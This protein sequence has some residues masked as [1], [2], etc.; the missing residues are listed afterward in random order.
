MCAPLWTATTVGPNYTAPAIA[1]GVVYLGT[2][3]TRS[4]AGVLDAFD[5]HGSTGCSGS[6]KVCT[7]L[8]RASFPDIVETPAVAAGYVYAVSSAGTLSAFD[9][10]GV[11]GCGGVPRTCSPRW[12]AQTEFGADAPIVA[13]GVVY[14][15]DSLA[16][17]AYD[18]VGTLG[19]SGS[20]KRCAPIWSSP[21]IS[22][23][24]VFDPAVVDGRLF[25]STATATFR[26][27]TLPAG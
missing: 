24:G 13:N 23:F 6:P 19:C 2:S 7:P 25:V 8:W 9:A 4:G 17:R 11:D 20:P 15:G 1:D 26:A 27:F 10:H 14:V 21:E 3:D 22:G 12:R 5:A 18:A 16:V